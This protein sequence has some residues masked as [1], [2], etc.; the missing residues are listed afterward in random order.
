MKPHSLSVLC[1]LAMEGDFSVALEHEAGACSGLKDGHK[2]YTGTL[3]DL[4]LRSR[5]GCQACSIVYNGLITFGGA[6]SSPWLE[7]LPEQ[8]NVS[9]KIK[10]SSTLAVLVR[11]HPA[12]TSKHKFSVFIEFLHNQGPFSKFLKRYLQV[13]ID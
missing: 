5:Q 8:C 3:S 4:G 2:E 6:W 11:H 1:P 12:I 9:W 7:I 10:D 13:D